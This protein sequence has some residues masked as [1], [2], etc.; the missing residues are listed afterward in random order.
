MYTVYI[1]LD[2]KSCIEAIDSNALIGD[3]ANWVPIDE[4]DTSRHMHAQTEYLPGAIVDDER[5]IKHYRVGAYPQ[6]GDGHFHTYERNGVAFGIYERTA[7]EMDADYAAR[8]APPPTDAERISALEAQLA[9]YEAAYNE[10][11]QSV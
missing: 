1:K 5:G 6:E 10:G 4:G 9:A 8:H 7:E 2:S 11:V 3:A